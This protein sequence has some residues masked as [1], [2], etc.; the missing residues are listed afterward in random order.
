[1]GDGLVIESGNH[2]ELLSSSG[3]YSALVQAQKLREGKQGSGNVGEEDESDPSEDT[4]DLE[5]MIREEIPLGRK[6]TNRSLASE[7]IEQKR[8]ATAQLETKSS[9]SLAYLFYRMGLLMKDHRSNYMV[10]ALAASCKF[11]S[12][13]IKICLLI[14]YV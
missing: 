6:T 2:D 10:A 14:N 8:V 5:K 3:A 12:L 7:I 11:D 9:Y 13:V 1:M 4:K